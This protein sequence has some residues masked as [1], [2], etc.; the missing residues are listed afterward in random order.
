MG[1]NK[2]SAS[3]GT[4]KSKIA[5][6]KAETAA[7][8]K[9]KLVPTSFVRKTLNKA[10]NSQHTVAR[11]NVERLRRLHPN[12]SPKQ[13][14]EHMN[15]WYIGVVSAAGAGAGAAAVVPNGF[16]QVPAA[17]ADFATYLEV[18]VLYVLSLSEIHMLDLE[19][20]ERRTLLVTVV[21]LGNSASVPILEQVV[22]RLA[23]HWGK[24]LVKA[25]PREAIRQ[26]NKVL[27][28]RFI[29]L[30]GTK[31]GVLVLGKQVPFMIGAAVGGVGN[32]LLALFV[33][34][35]GRKI[36]GSPPESWSSIADVETFKK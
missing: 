17:L 14:V 22:G 1:E 31:V 23:P 3:T 4:F 10:L 5:Q 19:D 36:L 34:K 8:D 18:S 28:P 11:A 33:V 25:I 2:S 9:A 7:S 21:L 6:V 20:V 32:G 30:T 13:L 29:T 26:A 35:S 15:K 16:V 27:G 12:K 24:A